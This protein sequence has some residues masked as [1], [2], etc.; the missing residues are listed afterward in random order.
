MGMSQAMEFAANCQ[1]RSG[2][3]R[4]GLDELRGAR[5]VLDPLARSANED[6]QIHLGTLDAFLGSA[7]G[8]T[9]QHLEARALLEA[10]AD[11]AKAIDADPERTDVRVAR[12]SVDG[13][14]AQ[15]L[16]AFG[17]LSEGEAL[18]RSC[19]ALDLRQE[20][21]RTR[22]NLADTLR[23]AGWL[24][25]AGDE[26]RAAFLA[27]SELDDDGYRESCR[28][29]LECHR[30]RLLLAC[31]E[32]DR[33]RGLATEGGGWAGPGT[34]GLWEGLLAVRVRAGDRSAEEIAA[35]ALQ[36]DRPPL[37]GWI[38]AEPVLATWGRGGWTS[39][40]EDATRSWME[41]TTFELGALDDARRRALSGSR[42]AALLLAARLTH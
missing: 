9:L 15:T 32:R 3:V 26:L 36:A 29:Y 28:R 41:R 20:E 12:L 17:E 31:G 34:T 27:L 38:L 6:A 22:G 5:G 35:E 37:F 40:L 4:R 24:D 7:L 39:D 42:E 11:A 14:L 25:Q 18:L 23:R 16:R 8:A 30:A 2:D 21:A 33:A 1:L 19:L 10:A 13:T